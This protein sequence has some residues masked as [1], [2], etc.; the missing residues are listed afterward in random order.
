MSKMKTWRVTA[1]PVTRFEPLFKCLDSQWQDPLQNLFAQTQVN[2]NAQAF[3]LK[4][5]PDF[6]RLMAYQG[7][8]SFVLGA[9]ENDQLLGAMTVNLDQVFFDGQKRWCA[10]TADLKVLAAARGRGVGDRLMQYAV[11]VSRAQTP[12]VLML[13]TVTADNPAGL[14][15]NQKLYPLVHMQPVAELDTVFF[16]CGVPAP[17]TGNPGAFYTRVLDLTQDRDRQQALALW[18]ARASYRQGQ[19]VYQDFKEPFLPPAQFWLGLF[20]SQPTP[21]LVGFLGLWDQRSYRQITLPNQPWILQQWLYAQSEAVSLWCVLHLTLEPQHRRHLPLLLAAA[22]RQVSQ[23]KGRLLGLAI[24][25]ADPL[26]AHLPRWPQQRNLLHLLSSELP[27]K[28]Y[29]FHGELALG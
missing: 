22:Q 10:Y 17:H 13:T 16:P 11:Q 12:D 23:Q 3:V 4:R 28:A 9:I 8:K 27:Q 7:Q 26:A 19:R 14:R 1:K 24:D 20:Q 18:Q 21:H 15:K 25:R 5:Q 2:H 29:P 6:F